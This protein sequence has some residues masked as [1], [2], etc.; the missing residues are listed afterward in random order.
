MSIKKR[1]SLFLILFAFV[2]TLGGEVILSAFAVRARAAVLTHSDVM[3]DLKADSSFDVSRYPLMTYDHFSA[4]NSDEDETNDVEF[5]SVIQI[6]ESQEKELFVYTYQPLNDV[7]DITASSITF[8]TS[9]SAIKDM[10]LTEDTVDFKKYDL[11]CVSYNG[12]FKKYLVEYFEVSDEFYRYY[13]ISEIERPFDTLLDEKISN[14]TIT[15][16]KAHSIGQAWCCYYENSE[17]KYE[18]VTLKLVEIEPTITDE[19]YYENG[20]TW[21]SLVGVESSCVSHYIAFNINNYDVDKIIDA[22]LVYRYRDY[23]KVNIIESGFVPGVKDVWNWI[24]GNESSSSTTTTVYPNGID[25]KIKPL[26]IYDT[27]IAKSDSKGLLAKKYSWNRI[28]T[29]SDF[30]DQYKDQGGSWNEI[31]ETTVKNSQFVFAFT[32]TELESSQTV[33]STGND[34]FATTTYTTTLDGTEVAQVD[35]LRLKFISNG[36]TYNLGVVGDTTTSDGKPGGVAEGL[37]LDGINETFEMLIRIICLIVLVIF[38]I[39]V[40]IPIAKPILEFVFVSIKILLNFILN[41][42]TFPIRLIFKPKQK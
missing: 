33:T 15:D 23:R 4:L 17:L 31:E 6:A 13:C 41:I 22:S 24:V 34:V 28:M 9:E 27:D 29:G 11:K 35:I 7:S 25:Y 8:A 19:L 21:G 5:L 40:V 36:V 18:M 2:F 39:N 16:F 14:E 12:P 20:I 30:V 3:D 38:V 42:L 32:E 37:D 26:N 10:D 1:I